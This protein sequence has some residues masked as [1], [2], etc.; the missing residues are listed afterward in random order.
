MPAATKPATVE[1][2]DKTLDSL[3]AYISGG[4]S[5]SNSTAYSRDV[6]AEARNHLKHFRDI[7]L[8]LEHDS[9]RKGK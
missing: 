8:G 5:V 4:A 3:S 2:L 6:C 7:L 1:Q 9:E